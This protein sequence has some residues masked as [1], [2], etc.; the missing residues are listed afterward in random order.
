[1]HGCVQY[2]FKTSDT[3]EFVYND[4]GSYWELFSEGVDNMLNWFMKLISREENTYGF[5]D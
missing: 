5:I 3:L 4:S 1:M 2:G